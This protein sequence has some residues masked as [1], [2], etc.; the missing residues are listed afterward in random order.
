MKIEVIISDDKLQNLSQS[1]K[2]EIEKVAHHYIEEVI[3]EGSRIEESRRTSNSN[4]EIT[5]AIINDAVYFAK[6][7]GIRYRRPKGQSLL[8]VFAFFSTICTGGLFNTGKF[9]DTPYI[10]IF[11]FVFTCSLGSTIYLAFNDKNNG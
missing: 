9:T 6:R 1:A 8:Q 11:L 3:D 4:P 10:L 5:A 7:Q 2:T